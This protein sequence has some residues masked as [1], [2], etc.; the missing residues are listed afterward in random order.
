MDDAASQT[1]I[2]RR[3]LTRWVSDGKLRAYRRAGDRRRYVDLDDIKQLQQLQVVPPTRDQLKAEL[4]RLLQA[5][6]VGR[7]ADLR[8]DR[9]RLREV[10]DQLEAFGMNTF[11]RGTAGQIKRAES[12]LSSR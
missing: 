9:A 10:C 7:S 12:L 11:D 4:G 2:G 1:G 3:T 6:E 5:L 8:R